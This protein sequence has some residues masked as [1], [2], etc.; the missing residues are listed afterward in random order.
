[1]G[2]CRAV[3][4]GGKS[5]VYLRQ[6][7]PTAGW[8]GTILVVRGNR[9]CQ[10]QMRK[11]VEILGLTRRGCVFGMGAVA[12]AAHSPGVWAARSAPAASAVVQLPVL[13]YAENA[14]DPVVSSYT[15]MIHYGRHHRSYVDQLNRAWPGSEFAKQSLEGLIAEAVGRPE[16]AALYV[17]AA[18]HWNHSFF[19][20]S[21]SP[22]GGGEPP[23]ALRV[24]IEEAFDSV[25]GLKRR[26]LDAAAAQTGSGWLWLVLDQQRLQVARTPNADPPFVRGQRPLLALD[27]WEHAY[28]LDYQERRA[29]YVNAVV[30]RLWNWEFAL[31]NLGP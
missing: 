27:I 20:K 24:R 31:Q 19:W 15:M 17:A 16:A 7:L 22:R 23:M 25:S 18:Q 28:Y 26:L 9:A 1:M 2:T 11:R 13:P 14:L 6:I 10:M 12:W 5:P 8:G 21:L 29:E 4:Y 30:D 3:K